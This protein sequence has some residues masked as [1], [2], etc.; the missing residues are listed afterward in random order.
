MLRP[1]KNEQTKNRMNGTREGLRTPQ[2]GLVLGLCIGLFAS[3]AS[4]AQ[5][6]YP[7]PKSNFNEQNVGTYTL[8]AP[9]TM[10][11]GTRVM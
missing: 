4:L 5:I 7:G 6:G 1:R 10:E 9:L 3:G 8:P 11:D 2:L